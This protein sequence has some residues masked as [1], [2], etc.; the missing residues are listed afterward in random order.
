MPQTKR[1]QALDARVRSVVH[2]LL[3]AGQFGRAV[4]VLAGGTL[5]AQIINLALS[6]VFTRLYDPSDFGILS[7]FASLLGL[8][9][10]AGSLRYEMAI[11]L[12]EQDDVAA[13][14]GAVAGVC[15]V[16]MTVLSALGVLLFGEDM[17][18]AFNAPGLT[19]YL[20]LLPVGVLTIGV[21]QILYY[22]SL[23]RRR[24]AALARTRVWQSAS[25]SVVQI[26]L[27]IWRPTPFGLIV[28]Q[29]V[30][31]AAGVTTLLRAAWSDRSLLSLVSRKTITQSARR[32]QDF[33][34][35]SLAG[36]MTN[37][38]G[39]L[40]P[41]LLVAWIYGPTVAG[42]FALTQRIIGLPMTIVGVAVGE[43]YWG[44]APQ[45][46]RE[47]PPG[48]R[49]LFLRATRRLFLMAVGPT[50]ALIALGPPLFALVFGAEWRTAGLYAAF[51]APAMLAQFAVSPLANVTAI[52]ER[53]R[54]QLLLDVMRLAALA[55]VFAAASIW[56]LSA[57]VAII[58][59]SAVMTVSYV[60]WFAVYYRL[61]HTYHAGDRA[62]PV[63]A[64]PAERDD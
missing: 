17:A 38:L 29:V 21:Y 28:G 1:R 12:P 60:V 11:P 41:A 47:D 18:V 13:S 24:Y 64:R 10:V 8:W 26:G 9:N 34:R 50:I 42:W 4:A 52:L 31:G 35:F 37:A 55:V 23:R 45:L 54:L 53:Q 57:A 40:A 5:T 20:W 49:R 46:A 36:G 62:E 3:P 58:L 22:W 30:G 56:G 63:S 16:G 59:M 6:P 2:K 32:Y 39:L 51:M 43:S 7:V 33:P 19:D 15:L 44:V 48:F 27:G 61:I 25:R 14:A